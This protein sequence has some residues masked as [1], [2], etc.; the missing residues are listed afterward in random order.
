MK[1]I[2]SVYIVEDYGLTRVTLK[3]Y[4]NSIDDI[5]II[6]DFEAAEDCIAKMEEEPADV[7]L[8][9]I[10]LPYMNGLEATRILKEKYPNTQIIALTSHDQQQEVQAALASGASA[11]ALK[12]TDFEELTGIIRSVSR[13]AGWF[14]PEV[15]DII[16]NAIPKPNS[17][18]NLESLYDEKVDLGLTE[19]ELEVLPYIVKGK[20]NSEIA[21]A[22]NISPHTV[23]AHV[24]S[25][26]T[27]FDAEDRIQVAVKAVQLKMV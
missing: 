23:K 17:T 3:K 18:K 20:S 16:R 27:K 25:I 5:D 12:D 21:A 6:G 14:D 24:S 7:I 19:K 22:L 8:M 1:N 2:I 10:G 11:Y 15:L 13:G 26:I 4:F 9:D